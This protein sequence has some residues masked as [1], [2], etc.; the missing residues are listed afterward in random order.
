MKKYFSIL[1]I[2]V[3]LGFVGIWSIVSGGYDNQNK[4]ILF[5]K[6]LIPNKIAK[7]VRDTIFIIP[8]LKEQN[9]VYKLQVTKYEQGYN[10][11]LFEEI[12]TKS[13]EKKY[14]Y[15]LKKFFLPF[16]RLDI[17]LGWQAEENSK[18]AHY[19]DIINE[20]V[21]V[22]SGLGETIY[23]KKENI[24]SEKLNQNKI[25]NNIEKILS[26]KNSKLLGIRDL[27]YD[28]NFIYISL[29]EM[30]KKGATM[31]IYRAKSNFDYLKFELFFETQE[32][33]EKYSLQ[34]GGRLEK[35]KDDKIL[36]SIGFLGKY[37]QAQKEN[38]LAGKIISIDK[39]SR[40]F[41]L[42]SKGH[43]N[44]QGLFYLAEDN[45]IINTEH[46]PKGGDEINLNFLSEN[47][48]KNYGWPI[49][50]YGEP[51]PQLK[52]LFK[53]K[54]YLKTS[55][56]ENNFEEPI[57]YF[58]PSIGISELIHIK[59]SPQKNLSRRIFASSLRASSIY[60][61]E[62]NDKYDKVINMDRVFIP[63]NRIRDLKYDSESKNF[64]A[65][66][67]N[68]PAIAVIKIN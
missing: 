51:Y 49:S 58:V 61:I 52:E 63:N 57:K 47:E 30:G 22:M 44:P 5:L 26:T 67:E 33:T 11:N 12:S 39:N 15:N 8:N 9:R 62:I 56:K 55:H 38:N 25:E 27:L 48:I 7:K 43:R 41:D 36:L 17:R 59:E 68:I 45:L 1:A 6:E 34:T 18:R 16:K 2:I 42:I 37:D 20:N 19:L 28:A 21:L 23:F 50:S 32:F 65:I 46:G 66:L 53:E 40:E 29:I 35:F 24:L 54:G 14:S 4:I 64:I 31:N 60:I 3:L 13:Q 10:G